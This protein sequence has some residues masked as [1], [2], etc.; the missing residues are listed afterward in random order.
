M[1][2]LFIYLFIYLFVCFHFVFFPG[3]ADRWVHPDQTFEMGNRSSSTLP[4]QLVEEMEEMTSFSY[5]EIT[6]LYRQFRHDCPDLK[7][8]V[9]QF[10]ILY[11]QTFPN[12]NPDSFAEHVFQTFDVEKRGY[13]DFR[14]FL[15]TLSSQ[16]K[17]NFQEKLEWLFNLYDNDKDNTI[18]KW[19]LLTMITVGPND[20]ILMIQIMIMIRSQPHF[21]R[22][23]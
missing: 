1:I 23:L 21:M 17:G 2:I 5:S 18:T 22:R 11:R 8:T 7:M 6:D 20:H 3:I 9:D 4:P 19:D 15:T 10:K 12:G 13:I 16:L 14:Q